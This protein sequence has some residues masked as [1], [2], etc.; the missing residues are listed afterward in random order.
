MGLRSLCVCQ[1]VNEQ[2]K[3]ITMVFVC[4][5]VCLVGGEINLMMA[6]YRERPLT[7]SATGSTLSPILQNNRH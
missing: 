5:C 1:S 4:V 7:E 3:Y 6:G 2:S